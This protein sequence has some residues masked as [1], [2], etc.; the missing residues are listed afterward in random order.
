MR[1]H[2]PLIRLAVAAIATIALVLPFGVQA[3]TAGAGSE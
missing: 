3:G 1:T 2:S